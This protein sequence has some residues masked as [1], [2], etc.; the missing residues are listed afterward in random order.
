MPTKEEIDELVENCHWEW[1]KQKGISGYLV[2]SKTNGNSIFLPAAGTL[3][4]NANAKQVSGLGNQGYY[5][6][7]SLDLGA[8]RFAKSLLFESSE[9]K[10]SIYHR[11][12]E[13]LVV[14]PVM[15]N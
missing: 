4:L 9:V 7:S 5:W 6:S 14:R 12:N 15:G 1:T 11:W 2:K 10:S 13:G 8:P 3:H